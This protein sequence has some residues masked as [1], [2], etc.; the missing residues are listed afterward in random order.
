MGGTGCSALAGF[1]VGVAVG[2]GQWGLVV[3]VI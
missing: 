3:N 1:G 2:V